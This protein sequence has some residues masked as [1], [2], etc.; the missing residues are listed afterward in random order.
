MLSVFTRRQVSRWARQTGFVKRPGRLNPFDFLLM[1]IFTPLATIAPSLES[2]VTYLDHQI[3]RVALH[4]RFSREASQFL[5]TCLEWIIAQS[6]QL[7]LLLQTGLLDPFA[8]VLI[9]DSSSWD[10]PPALH[11]AFAGSGGSASPANG[12]LHL[13]Y[14]LKRGLLKLWPL[15][16][17]K[18]PDQA[19]GAELLDAVQPKDLVLVDL[20]FFSL[21]FLAGVAQK[22]AYFLSRFLIGTALWSAETLKPIV[23]PQVLK[24]ATGDAYQHLVVIGT[25][26]QLACR[27]IALRVPELIV[28]RRRRQLKKTAQKKGRTPSRLHLDLCAWTLL[29]TNAPDALL[30][31]PKIRTFYRLRWQVELVFKQFKSVLRLHHCHTRNPYRLLGEVYGKLIAAVLVHSLHGCVNAELWNSQ[32]QQLSFDKFWKRFQE[33]ALKFFEGSLRCLKQFIRGFLRELPK[34]LKACLKCRQPSRPT[35]LERLEII[36]NLNFEAFPI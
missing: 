16:A 22:S 2:M 14:E 23:L 29:V 21:R 4:Y 1:M 3:S 7:H 17:G 34:L 26:T 6:Q 35:S 27:L 19:F 5:W 36:E 10:L 8:R 13:S 18:D 31:A 12:K 20:G 24:K 11:T 9:H 25:D 32:R 33:R 28:Q 30:P 15:R